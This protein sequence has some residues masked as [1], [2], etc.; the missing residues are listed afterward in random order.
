MRSLAGPTGIPID[1]A[2]LISEWPWVL[3]CLS[4]E[5]P[6]A[7]HV[8]MS[9]SRR[10][11]SRASQGSRRASDAGW[12][13]ELLQQEGPIGL[14][15]R[16]WLARP[17]PRSLITVTQGDLHLGRSARSD[18]TRATVSVVS[19]DGSQVKELPASSSDIGGDTYVVE[20]DGAPRLFSRQVRIRIR[21]TGLPTSSQIT[22]RVL[23]LRPFLDGRR[24]LLASWAPTD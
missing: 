6:A 20:V 2:T 9:A 4:P 7:E 3:E 15:S 14:N 10:Q 24:R 18:G 13:L 23:G 8:L 11:V 21:L 19:T 17:G 22:L 5:I 1:D 12:K 16:A